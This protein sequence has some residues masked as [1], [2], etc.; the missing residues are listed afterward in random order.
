[1][2]SNYLNS[3]SAVAGIN[4]DIIDCK[5]SLKTAIICAVRAI[6]AHT[7]RGIECGSHP[8]LSEME[9]DNQHKHYGHC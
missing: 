6:F 7:L 2:N 8:E 9:N 3:T 5:F 1:M 4:R